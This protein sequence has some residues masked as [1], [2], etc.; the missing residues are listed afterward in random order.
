MMQ[1]TRRLAALALVAAAWAPRSALAQDAGSPPRFR[2]FPETATSADPGPAGAAPAPQPG[3][4]F[5]M[6]AGELLGLEGVALA[7]NRYVADESY[8][9]VSWES[10]RSNLRTGFAF[11]DD[12][13]TTNQLGHSWGGGFYFNAP[14]TNGLS[15][16]ESVPFVLAGSALWEMVAE[17]QGP[18]FND[19]VNT[20]LGGAVSGEA[21]YRLSQMVLDDRARGGARVLR[22]TVAAVLNPAQLITRITTGDLW[23]VRPERGDYLGPSRFVAEIDAGW[24]HFVSSSRAN[25]DQALL[26]LNLRYGDPFLRAVSRPFDSFETSLDLSAPS[27]AWLT[28]V[29]I[30]GLLGGWDLDPG[31]AK[32]RHVLGL[33]MD[34]DYTNN[35]TRLFSSQSFRF[36][37]LSM[38][39]LG[40]DVELRA[41]ALGVVAPLVALQNDHADESHVLV[42]R[43]YDYGPGVAVFTA[44]RIR[45]SELD[46]A[47]LTYS[48]FWTH[49]SNGIARNSSIQSF[50]AEARIPVAGPCSVGGSWSWGKRISTYEEFDTFRTGATQWRA[51]VS[52]MFR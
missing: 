16:W 52:C 24:R 13:F 17:I 36:G 25:P 43:A 8:A 28:R 29:E 44:I 49:T 5:W 48:L 35:D 18:S 3:K 1:T 10:V 12:K 4:R 30:R 45:R 39:P 20:T 46:L 26:T 7:F 2:L 15:F 31:S 32:G 51:F 47:A 22:E 42:G 27:S 38:R 21:A 19:L 9:R 34:F 14:R 41:E 50:R 40:K 33:F 6:A 11:D 23:A 37:L